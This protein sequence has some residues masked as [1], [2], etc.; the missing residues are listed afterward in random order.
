M[1]WIADAL[2]A[3]VIGSVSFPGTYAKLKGI[4][5]RK[6][7]EGHLGATS[8]YT[9]T[10]SIT[11]FVILG[12][13]DAAKGTLAYYIWG[14]VGWIFAMV[15]HMFPL[16]FGFRGGNA[17]S[18]YYGGLLLIDP[19]LVIACVTMELITSKSVKSKWR[20]AAYLLIRAIPATA[21]KA[22]VP[23]Y[24]VL[25]IRHVWFYAVKFHQGSS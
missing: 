24:I 18:V 12:L 5:L 15:G 13:L 8:I 1:Q 19:I 4:D 20:H 25:L 23:A 9:A 16:F 14:P 22:V 2:A 10:G 7:G 6:T 11:E 21:Y 17:V 3:Y